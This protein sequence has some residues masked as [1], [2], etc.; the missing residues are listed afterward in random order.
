M[1]S[2][3]AKPKIAA[4]KK[5][6]LKPNLMPKF[7]EIFP[8]LLTMFRY[9]NGI[10]PQLL[11]RVKKLKYIKN[12]LNFASK[13]DLNTL[14]RFKSLID[15]FE[16]CLLKHA[17]C[18]DAGVE[19]IEITQCWANRSSKDESHHLHEHPNSFLSGVF[20]LNGLD[21]ETVFHRP[22]LSPFV[23]APSQHDVWVLKPQPGYLLIFPSYLKHFVSANN[24]AQPRYTVSFNAIPRGPFGNKA[25]RAW[26]NL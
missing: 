2:K 4:A 26:I 9:E 1:K 24:S 22:N 21:G 6:Q 14:P 15:F 10:E 3:I 17:Q 20:Y 11:N 13:E 16:A 12:T 18:I 7:I 23:A 8:T 5:T 19:R 25:A